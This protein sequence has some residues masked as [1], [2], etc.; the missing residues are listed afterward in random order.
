MQSAAESLVPDY[1]CDPDLT[2]FTALDGEE[3][4]AAG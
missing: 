1:T 2:A 4:L 3:F